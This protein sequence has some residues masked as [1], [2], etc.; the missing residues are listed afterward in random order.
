MSDVKIQELELVDNSEFRKALDDY[1]DTLMSSLG[2]PKKILDEFHPTPNDE[3]AV[4]KTLRYLKE[5]MD[6]PMELKP[7]Q[8]LLFTD[9]MFSDHGMPM[10]VKMGMLPS[11]LT[12]TYKPPVDYN[13]ETHYKC[14]TCGE[15]FEKGVSDEEAETELITDFP[16][17]DKSECAIVCDDCYNQMPLQDW[18]ED[19]SERMN[20]DANT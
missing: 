10:S 6:K 20:A 12:A 5:I 18:K 15:V 19:W 2:I 16:G 9:H 1:R 11:I 3:L 4:L 17:M 8:P 14:A 7:Y 13:P